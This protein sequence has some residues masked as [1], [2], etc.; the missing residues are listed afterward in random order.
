VT[1]INRIGELIERSHYENPDLI[2][3]DNFNLFLVNSNESKKK[4]VQT[5]YD[6]NGIIA[7]W[8]IGFL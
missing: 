5:R 6:K 4:I 8:P 3:E 2:P 1:I 7:K